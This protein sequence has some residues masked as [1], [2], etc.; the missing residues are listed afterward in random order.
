MKKTLALLLGFGFLFFCGSDAYSQAWKNDPGKL[1][2]ELEEMQNKLDEQRTLFIESKKIGYDIFTYQ[3]WYASRLTSQMEIADSSVGDTGSISWWIVTVVRIVD[4]KN[5][6]LSI[7]RG[8]TFFW[9]ED[10]PT[11][12]LFTDQKLFVFGEI[13]VVGSKTVGG[14]QMRSMRLTNPEEVK[15]QKAEAA[16]ARLEAS[17]RKWERKDGKTLEARFDSYKGGNVILLTKDSREV[18]IKPSELSKGDVDFYKAEQKRLEK[19]ME[20]ENTRDWFIKGQWITAMFVSEDKGKVRLRITEN[21]KQTVKTVS[22]A[23][24]PERDKKWIEE[25]KGNA[26]R[27]GGGGASETS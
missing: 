22:L 3:E 16:K 27:A 8:K 2:Y 26:N 1:A 10:Y 19:E 6:I 4:G 15:K 5:C 20:E 25:A 11:E 12:G 13:K 9:L 18:K 17:Y 7:H 21:K 24:L 23:D 14:I